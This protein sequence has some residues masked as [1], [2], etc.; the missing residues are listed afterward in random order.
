MGSFPLVVMNIG[1][2]LSIVL[3]SLIDMN[4]FSSAIATPIIV[5]LILYFYLAESPVWLM[6]QSSVDE[7]NK[8]LVALRGK[9]YSPQGE[10]KEIEDLMSEGNNEDPTASWTSRAFLL[11]LTILSALFF[12]HASFGAD[13]ISTYAMTIF[14]FPGIPLSPAVMALLFQLGW[15]FAF[16][17]ASAL[18]TKI[19]R[20]KQFM[21]GCLGMASSLMIL[22]CFHFFNMLAAD[23]PLITWAAV[24]LHIIFIVAFGV[25]CGPIPHTLT[26]ELFP[27]Q[28]KS[29][30]CGITIAVRFLAQFLQLRLYHPLKAAVGMSGVYWINSITALVACIFVFFLLPETR[31]MSISQ[32][33]LVFKKQHKA[34]SEEGGDYHK[35]IKS[36]EIKK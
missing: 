2:S 15:T 17:I 11:P 13:V 12:F 35:N 33:N 8:A 14:K 6:Q 3:G 5:F 23:Q 20:R 36:V 21:G 32:L 28:L 34:D 1:Y 10:L 7:A 31:N 27:Q 25:G 26:G 29:F 18:M 22:G 19:G 4:Y 24:V 16:I 30:G 9:T